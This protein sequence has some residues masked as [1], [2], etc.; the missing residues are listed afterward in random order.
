MY[1]I[2]KSSRLCCE[3]SYIITL[4]E[5][6]RSLAVILHWLQVIRLG[7][8]E[9]ARAY[10]KNCERKESRNNNWPL[11]EISAAIHFGISKLVTHFQRY[12]LRYFNYKLILSFSSII[13]LWKLTHPLSAS[14]VYTTSS[15]H[16]NLCKTSLCNTVAI[17]Q[18]QSETFPRQRDKCQFK[19]ISSRT[20]IPSLNTK[21]AREQRR[22]TSSR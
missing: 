10:V 6:S 16:R 15:K 7:K 1:K 20:D 2:L 21:L 14:N 22:R 13:S 19:R 4:L 8:R 12:C 11:A 3:S 5:S 18:K 9:C 17:F